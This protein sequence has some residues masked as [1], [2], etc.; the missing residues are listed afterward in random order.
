MKMNLYKKESGKYREFYV[1]KLLLNYRT[2]PP[3]LNIISRLFYENELQSG[4]EQQ[5]VSPANIPA[6]LMPH[7]F[8]FQQLPQK[9]HQET[10]ISDMPIENLPSCL[11]NKQL[12]IL[13]VN[14]PPGGEKRH[15]GSFSWFNPIEMIKVY[16][17]ATS[18]VKAN[19]S[20]IGI[21]TP[22]KAQ[23][24]GN[25][26]TVTKMITN[27]FRNLKTSPNWENVQYTSWNN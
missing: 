11:P 18:L 25:D 20:D 3:V 16:H 13:F 19:I 2:I 14:I 21:I 12:P 5:K 7:N 22:Y 4:H 24:K 26:K 10:T 9:C 23:L 6:N 17:Y 8:A 15:P 1:V 27:D